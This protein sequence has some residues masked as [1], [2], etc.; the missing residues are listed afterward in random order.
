MRRARDSARGESESKS[1]SK[2]LALAPKAAPGGVGSS[3]SS[4]A[5]AAA[6]AASPARVRSA[7]DSDFGGSSVAGSP[8]VDAR[9]LGDA[10]G[11]PELTEK[12]RAKKL[13][14][15]ARVAA[16]Q[17][18]QFTAEDFRNLFSYSRHG[19]YKQVA[20]LLKA[21]C[22]AEGKD[23]FRNTPLIIACQNGNAR[24]VKALLRHGANIDAQNKQ[25]CTG[26]HYCIRV[27]VQRSAITS[28]RRAQR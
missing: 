19:N 13:E 7:S 26:L 20:E 2:A 27:P 5:A 12:Q 9:A 22:P 11:K 3:S 28:S 8:G 1:K 24:I 25:G 17:R 6:A 23:Q 21:G 18:R 15:K 14:Q 4:S 16:N 10:R